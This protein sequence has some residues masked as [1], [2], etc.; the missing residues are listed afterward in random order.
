MSSVHLCI[1]HRELLFALSDAVLDGGASKIVVLDDSVVFSATLRERLDEL[2]PEVEFWFTSDR[3]ILNEFQ[4]LPEILP[5]L[6][7]RNLRRG[8]VRP[9]Q[10]QPA[11]LKG[12]SFDVGYVYNSSI[13]AAK[14]L[15]G[16]CSRIVLR[17]NG[18]NNYSPY[19]SSGLKALV[20]LLWGLSPT[21]QYLGEEPWVDRIEVRRPEALPQKLW[22][23]AVRHDPQM[24][25]LD[26]SL[27]DRA[28][29]FSVFA[30]EVPAIREDSRSALL[31]TQPLELIDICTEREKRD[32]YQSLSNEVSSRGYTVY[33]KN[34]PRETP[35]GL[36][37]TQSVDHNFPVEILPLGT[38]SKFSLGIALC[39]ASLSGPGAMF[40]ARSLQLVEPEQFN[41]DDA[42]FWRPRLLDNLRLGLSA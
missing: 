23:K 1:T 41:P 29:L 6:V 8:F 14:V 28:R 18:L 2:F 5:D 26:L 35:Y 39:S 36:D 4:T 10:W 31:L 37:G 40:C 19:K 32:L 20:R 38:N 25:I 27:E 21:E 7:R 24:R 30:P 34:H 11:R 3:L 33:V 16:V 17:E 15:S 9:D 42:A 22:A 12:R 13:F